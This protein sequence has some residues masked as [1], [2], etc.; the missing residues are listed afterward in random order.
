MSFMM[1]L[2][3]HITYRTYQIRKPQN[4]LRLEIF[5]MKFLGKVGI[6]YGTPNILAVLSVSIGTNTITNYSLL[7]L[8]SYLNVLT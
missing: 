6:K 1:I 7:N 3:S 4:G 8:L 5:C 2:C